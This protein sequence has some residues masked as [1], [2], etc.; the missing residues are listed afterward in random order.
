MIR[1]LAAA[2]RRGISFTFYS[3]TS[4]RP[5]DGGMVK[6]RVLRVPRS[7]ARSKL[8]G[9]STGTLPGRAPLNILSVELAELWTRP[10]ILARP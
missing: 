4:A 6:P 10:G 5:S 7:I 1:V 2:L 8:V 3:I 9:R